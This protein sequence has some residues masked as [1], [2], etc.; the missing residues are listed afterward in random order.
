MQFLSSGK[1]A[2]FP[3]D[4]KE[5][6]KKLMLINVTE[7]ESRVGVI[8]D[9]T[10]QELLIE[11][12]NRTQ[13][14]GNV[15]KGVVVQVQPSIQAAFVDFGGEKNG[16]LPISDV[17]FSVYPP[18]NSQGRNNSIQSRLKVGQTIMV[19]VTREP[20]GHK[21]AALSTY[22]SLPGRFMVFMP[23]SSHG[24]VSKRIDNDD[25]RQRLKSFLAGIESEDNSVI[26]R[27]AGE[28]RDLQELKKD[29]TMLKRQ[30]ADIKKEFHFQDNPGV[31]YQEDDVVVRTLR[32]YYTEDTS[33]I[34]VDNP[35]SFQKAL[36]F[37]KMAD[38]RK[39]RAVKLFVGTRSL[40]A[41]YGIEKQVEQL[42][43]REVQLKSG[44]SIVIDPTEALVAIDVNSG[45]SRQESNTKDTALRTNLEAAEEVARQLR[46]RNLGGLIVVDFIDMDTDEDR[47]KV[48]NKLNEG[49]TIDKAQHTIGKISQFGLLELSRQRMAAGFAKTVESTCPTCNGNGRI[50]SQ[51]TS[52]NFILRQI[53]ELA[54]KGNAVEIKGELPLGIANHLLNEKR[55]QINDLEMEFGISIV[56]IANPSLA[57]VKDNSI[58]ITRSAGLEIEPEE[59]FEQE[60]ASESESSKKPK[61]KRGRKEKY[62][63][64][65]KE[66][67]TQDKVE[68][69]VE[70]EAPQAAPEEKPVAEKKEEVETEIETAVEE[71]P[72]PK[73]RVERKKPVARK[74]T[75]SDSSE[76]DLHPGC[77]FTEVNELSEDEA[78]A[79]AESFQQRLSGKVESQEAVIIED[80]FLW[81]TGAEKPVP[82]KY[83]ERDLIN[84]TKESPDDTEAASISAADEA[85]AEAQEE[86]SDKPAKKPAR[87]G[88]K[89]AKAK[90]EANQEETA[91]EVESTDPETAED[92]PAKKKPARKAPARKK[93]TA[94]KEETSE[95]KPAAKTR[96]RKKKTEEESVGDAEVEKPKKSPGRRKKTADDT[97]EEKVEKKPAAKKAP[98]KTSTAKKKPSAKTAETDEKPAKAAKTTTRKSASASARK[99]KEVD[100]S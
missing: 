56:L 90:K 61:K 70:E 43:S 29:Y 83:V 55:D 54:A 8:E 21:G 45:R 42:T 38:P 86:K 51:L 20:A 64:G 19:Q 100:E 69:T 96:G 53:R 46:L 99:K 44:G 49:M 50:P 5:M 40:F 16:F 32:D 28:G 3:T 1:F 75:Q 67:E 62:S 36:D 15:Y 58:K 52:A 84:G 66:E 88:R 9:N 73:K 41:A 12:Q 59:Y 39:Q 71:K 7:D 31:I 65:R 85:V 76:S 2:F 92:K 27:T 33:E 47:K 14:K 24:G 79:L 98:R 22:I 82:H 93:T 10:L 97:A 74:K 80:K 30:W 6:K 89:P 17:N 37:M 11:H 81:A 68:E 4:R 94:Q 78:E 23:D 34:W 25:E 77:K 13:L 72:E 48:E 63:R 57:V 87:R 26:I 60:D 91:E 35:N 95:E 18:H